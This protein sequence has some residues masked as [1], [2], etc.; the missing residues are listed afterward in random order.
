MLEVM[1]LAIDESQPGIITQDRDKDPSGAPVNVE[2][3]RVRGILAESQDVPPGWILN[4]VRNSEVVR[5]NVDDHAKPGQ[6]GTGHEPFQRLRSA[7]VLVDL[8]DIGC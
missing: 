4:R 5:H 7:P 2:P 3:W 6:A 1:Q 8:R